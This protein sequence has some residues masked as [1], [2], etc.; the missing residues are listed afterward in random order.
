[1]VDMNR[2]SKVAP[3]HDSA[4]H[5]SSDVVESTKSESEF[6]SL[7]SESESKSTGLESE[8]ESESTGL[9]SESESTGSRVV[10]VLRVRVR[11][12]SIQ[13]RV[14]KIWTL[15]YYIIAPQRSVRHIL[16]FMDY[17]GGGLL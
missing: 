10:R 5:H 1:M 16:T 15:E 6:E 17:G 9:E 7:G 8:S 13:V 4:C 2:A 14:L 12:L 11:V 3:D